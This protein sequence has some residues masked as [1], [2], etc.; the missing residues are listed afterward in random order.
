MFITF[1]GLDFSGKSTQA[2]LLVESLRAHHRTVHF[3]REPGGTLLSEAIRSILLDKH[4]SGMS[5]VAEVLLFSASRSQ[6]VSE[7]IQP[8]LVRKEVVVCDRYCDSTTA[9][10][11]YGRGLNLADVQAINRLATRG[12]MP[13]LTI[14]VDIPIDEIE[15][16]K[17]AAGLTFDRMESSGRQFYQRVSDGYR[18]LM[19]EEPE[20]WFRVDGLLPVPAI[21]KAIWHRVQAKLNSRTSVSTSV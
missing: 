14:L 20:R 19:L 17:T 8:A 10:Q 18:R 6:L 2:A 4:H 5:D 15:R 9:Y 13:D 16:R 11:G 1:E 7:V 21:A 12:T 3:L